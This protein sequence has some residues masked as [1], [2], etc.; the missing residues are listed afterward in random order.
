MIF[1]HFDWTWPR[2]KGQPFFTLEH[3][4]SPRPFFPPS[5]FLF[6]PLNILF[7]PSNLLFHPLPI[8]LTLDPFFFTLFPLLGVLVGWLAC[9]NA[10]Q[11]S[12]AFGESTGL[13]GLG[14]LVCWLFACLIGGWMDGL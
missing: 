7:S 11:V 8:F 5:T 9:C 6:R 2:Y 4:F 13:C 12:T 3:C 10:N 14:C 1:V